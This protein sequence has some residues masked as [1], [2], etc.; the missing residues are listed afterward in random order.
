MKE[1]D[2]HPEGFVRSDD[3]GVIDFSNKMYELNCIVTEIKEL[4]NR[5]PCD[6]IFDIYPK[7]HKFI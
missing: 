6:Q 7:P 1:Y 3:N 4:R 2:L 5:Q